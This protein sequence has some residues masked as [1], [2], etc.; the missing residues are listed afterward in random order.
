MLYMPSLTFGATAVAIW[1][2]VFYIHKAA[3]MDPHNP[4]A[5]AGNLT[6][7]LKA[8]LVVVATLATAAVGDNHIAAPTG[9]FLGMFALAQTVSVPFVTGS[10][11]TEREEPDH[12]TRIFLGVRDG[13]AGG[14]ILKVIVVLLALAMPD[15]V[16][17]YVVLPVIFLGTVLTLGK[18]FLAAVQR[19]QSSPQRSHRRKAAPPSTRPAKTPNIII[20]AIAY[21][22]GCTLVLNFIQENGVAIDPANWMGWSGF[23]IGVILNRL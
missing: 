18:V 21:V 10:K 15:S 7:A 9:S 11:F 6:S 19:D 14:I 16:G 8:T 22:F 4:W 12:I 17:L 3:A 2:S 23:L 1:F 5:I 13:I 20:A